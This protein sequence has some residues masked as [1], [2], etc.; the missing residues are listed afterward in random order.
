MAE[1]RTV[2]KVI[3]L[4]IQRK[5]KIRQAKKLEELNICKPVRIV[6]DQNVTKRRNDLD[7]FESTS[8]KVIHNLSSKQLSEIDARVLSIGLEYGIK[9]K[10]RELFSRTTKKL[11][12]CK[13]ILFLHFIFELL[14]SF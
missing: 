11:H 4:E 2:T 3:K 12:N 7:K 14:Y 6:N 5:K 9:S 8:A 10:P 13:L 1:A